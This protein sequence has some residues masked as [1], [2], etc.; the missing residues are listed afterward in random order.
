MKNSQQQNE[1]HQ[2]T[3]HESVIDYRSDIDGLRALAI[4]P[5]LIF[6][7]FPSYLT[8]GF[9]G[10]D[11]FFV[12]SGFLITGI[13]YTQLEKK[14]F[15]FV[16]FYF[17]RIRRIFPALILVAAVTFA[18]GYFKLAPREMKSL[19]SSLMGTAGFAQNFV[20]LSEAGYFD[21]ASSGK[22]LLHIWSL[23]IEEQYYI[24][25]PLIL[26]FAV[27]FRLNLVT[28]L[29]LSMVLSFANCVITLRHSP[30]LAFY[31][32]ASRAWELLA[33]SLLAILLH[34]QNKLP[35]FLSVWK[36]RAESILQRIIWADN[37]TPSGNMLSNFASVTA[38]GMLAYAILRFSDQSP[39]P[40]AR[41]LVPVIA[42]LLLILSQGSTF[43]RLVLSNRFV[44]GIGL[45]SYPL[46]L[47]HFPLLA[48]GP[49]LSAYD[50]RWFF[51]L[52]LLFAA[53]ALA[54]IT[55]RF[56]E[57]PI[58]NRPAKLRLI[59]LL[60]TGMVIIGALGAAIYKTD[61]MKF[62]FPDYVQAFFVPGE[63]TSA[64][65][66]RGECLL[67]PE[68]GY[69]DF[70]PNCM[71]SG[72]HPRIVLWGDSYAAAV[73]QGFVQLA[74]EYHTSVGWL[75]SSA[76]PP[77]MGFT[78]EPRPFCKGNNDWV[79]EQIKKTP[80]DILI[81]HSTWMYNFK[82][83]EAGLAATVNNLRGAGIKKIVLLGPVS[84]WTGAGLPENFLDY[85]LSHYSLM[86]KYTYYL[87]NHEL[88][89]KIEQFLRQQAETLKISYVSLLD[90]MCK[91]EGCLARVGDH[92][93]YLTAID[94]GHLTVQAATTA[95]R[96][97]LP[98]IVK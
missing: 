52:F 58:R 69:K 5:V 37:A 53:A 71:P 62:R 30:E 55:Y 46:Y 35:Q 95:V 88:D 83:T 51:R 49:S 32:P 3:L 42:T 76:C 41:A 75:T 80:P 2:K 28:L 9:V 91:N 6:H 70:A 50:P 96:E 85:Y 27:R 47:W 29:L 44:V 72:Q 8:G 86:P 73:A 93:Q 36:N 82:D 7:A 98:E 11:I 78:S 19:G 54:W 43:N 24:F 15:S 64:S 16:G 77:F 74:S 81:L 31:S 12:I 63:V 89:N 56:L 20:L 34:R 14:K 67:L 92:D 94:N 90:V 57:T 68:Q 97:I 25:W 18:L 1:A 4:L 38:L 39:Y 59:A 10:V 26:F 21:L 79:L 13:I 22:P 45:I 33:G 23:G 17:K 66:R 60:C 65:W 61:G 87:S 48:Y 84:S 40:G